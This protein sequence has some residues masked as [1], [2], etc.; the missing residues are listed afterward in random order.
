MR[1]TG[2]TKVTE[3]IAIKRVSPASAMPGI[4]YASHLVC[5]ASV[6]P[7]I[8]YARHLVY[9]AS[10]MP[11]IWYARHL[12]CQASGMAGIWHGMAWHGMPSFGHL[13]CQASDIPGIWHGR[14]LARPAC[15]I[16]RTLHT[17]PPALS[18]TR[19][20]SNTALSRT[21]ASRMN[22]E[23]ASV[24]IQFLWTDPFEDIDVFRQTRMIFI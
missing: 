22:Q 2:N 23:T 7:G 17:R 1:I 19:A 16:S 20:L 10:G 11:G 21:R 18:R 24:N 3:L 12:V 6:M 9:Q 15:G 5:Q 8:W 14:Y 4:W 13:V